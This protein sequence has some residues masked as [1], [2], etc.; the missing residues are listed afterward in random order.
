[1]G[2]GLYIIVKFAMG[3]FNKVFT[4]YD[5]LNSSVQEN[6]NGIR[7]VKT[8]VRED[9]EKQKFAKASDDVCENFVSAE[10]IVAWN[11]PIMQFSMYTATI[12]VCFLLQE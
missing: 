4:K 9:F 8:Y 1:M 7:V 5:A 2:V 12:L 6:I 3:K 10:K 11:S